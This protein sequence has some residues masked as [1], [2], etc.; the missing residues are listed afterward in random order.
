MKKQNKTKQKNPNK[1]AA[2][3][4]QLTRH[5]CHELLAPTAPSS[6]QLLWQISIL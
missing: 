6:L 4:S 3:S 2:V 1:S 5:S